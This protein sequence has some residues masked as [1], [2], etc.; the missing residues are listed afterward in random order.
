MEALTEAFQ[1]ESVRVFNDSGRAWIVGADVASALGYAST[2]DYTRIVKGKYTQKVRPPSGGRKLTVIS[3]P[4]VWQSLARTQKDAAEPFQD[5]LYEEVLPTIRKTGSYD[6]PAPDTDGLTDRAASVA[7]ELK[8]LKEEIQR[9]QK[10]LDEAK[11]QLAALIPGQGDGREGEAPELAERS[12]TAAMASADHLA[13][14]EA[15]GLTL[16]DPAAYAQSEAVF[17]LE[18]PLVLFDLETTGLDPETDKITEIAMYRLV[19]GND[20][21]DADGRVVTLV[22]PEQAIPDKVTDIT[23]ITEEDVA[24][25][26]TFADLMDKIAA[27]VQDADFCG[28][29]AASF[30][31][32]FLRKMFERH[33]QQLP[34]PPSP[35]VVDPYMVERALRSNQLGAVYKR[36]TGRSLEDA[37]EA[38]A[39]IRATWEVLQHQLRGMPFEGEVSAHD[40]AECA[41]GDFLDDKQNFRRDGSNV[42][43]CFGKHKGK[44]LEDLQRAEPSYVDWMLN[45]DDM[46]PYVKKHL[47]I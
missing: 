10:R 1:G 4:G 11:D 35:V 33:G 19:P 28:Y 6:A 20:G 44:T 27:L 9:R 36:Y 26:P 41:R 17:R 24:N 40:V 22:N 43:V 38:D 34:R 45:Q 39:D 30:D 13:E 5:W 8:E 46:A 16:T 47:E 29:N 42:L 12:T 14:P 23:G 37:H 7:G 2:H 21:P 18:R 31:V 15:R 32:P 25:A 3:E